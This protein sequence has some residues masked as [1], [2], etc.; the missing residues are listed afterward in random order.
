MRNLQSAIRALAWSLPALLLLAATPAQALFGD[1]E[2]RKAILELR[3]RVAEQEK[4]TQQRAEQAQ[5]VQADL[6]KRL[7]GAQRSQLEL[8]NQIEALKQEITRLRGQNELLTNELA[9]L[10]KRNR[11]LY[12]DLDARLKAMEPK[13]IT[14]DGKPFTIARDEQSAYDA[15]LVLFRAS[16]FP[17]AIRSFQ[18]FL[19]RYP[20][21]V[22][23]P[24][25]H[26][27]IGNAYY[28]QKDYKSA[29]G[30]Q[31]LVVDRFADTPRAPEA[32][33]NIAASQE[34]M[35]QRAAARTTLQKLMKEYP[36]SES[37]RLAKDRLAAL[38]PR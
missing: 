1:D 32:L 38:G 33:L 3:A 10:Q 9:T 31:Q 17:A 16:D 35:K 14:V 19:A 21:S 2:A 4:Q 36:D 12:G 8:F 22:Y 23:V 37:A 6:V 18:S 26:Y 20:Q 29:I 30:A 11:D 5:A 7:E 28:A 34:E 25:A 15:A 24:S 27:W 13:P